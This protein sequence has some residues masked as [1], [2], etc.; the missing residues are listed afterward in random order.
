M[1]GLHFVVDVIVFIVA[2]VVVVV[3]ISFLM[4]GGCA[5]DRL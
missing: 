2:V 4:A 1:H 3:T 5:A